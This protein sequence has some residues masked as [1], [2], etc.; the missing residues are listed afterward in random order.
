[1][2]AQYIPVLVAALLAIMPLVLV[3]HGIGARGMLREQGLNAHT[4][5]QALLTQHQAV[6]RWAR[7][8]PGSTG[9]VSQA[10]LTFPAPWT[11]PAQVASLVGVTAG[12][13]IAV[14]WYSGGG[15]TAGALGSALAAINENSQDV[16]ITRAGVLNSADGALTPVPAGVP[17]GVAAAA[18]VVSP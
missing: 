13:T 6:Q 18:D 15:V 5:A 8:N 12:G 3:N 4:L 9:L 14:T 17:A 10:A 2:L 16:G 11:A 1:M 7:A